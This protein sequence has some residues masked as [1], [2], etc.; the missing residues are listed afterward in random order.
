M[1]V[2]TA[3]KSCPLSEGSRFR[4]VPISCEAFSGF[5]LNGEALLPGMRAERLGTNLKGCIP[6]SGLLNQLWWGLNNII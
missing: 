4:E 3:H 1:A 5:S 2:V 6:T